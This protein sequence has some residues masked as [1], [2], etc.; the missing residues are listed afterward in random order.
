[1]EITIAQYCE[2]RTKFG[3]K[4]TPPGVSMAI[5]RHD[6]NNKP[7]LVGK[8]LTGVK[9]IKRTPHGNYMLVVEADF[10]GKAK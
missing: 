10:L 2:H 9:K 3:K 8:K 4:I 6:L 1:M 5:K 7:S